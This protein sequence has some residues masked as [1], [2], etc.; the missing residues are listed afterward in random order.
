[1]A[2]DDL[3]PAFFLTEGDHYLGTALARGPWD[4]GAAH[5]GPVAALIGREVE[6][7]DPDPDLA[8][9]RLTIELLRPVPLAR[10]RLEVTTLRP[11]RRVRIIGVSVVHDGTE[12]ARAVA[13]RV[14]RA[15]EDAPRSRPM[16]PSPFV[17]PE[18]AAPASGLVPGRVGITSGVELRTAAGSALEPGPATYWFRVHR[19]LVDYEPISPLTRALIAADFG[20]GISSVVS[21]DSHVFINPDLTVHLHRLPVGEW[22]A[23]DAVTWLE[24]GGAAVADATLCDLDG[25][26]GRAVQSLY[27]ASR[28]S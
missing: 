9:V 8:T 24:P 26:I 3:P 27:V 21:I 7:H 11:G 14:R 18:S 22:I 1:M 12:V 20:N 25:P 6:R 23:N 10:L 13:L 15:A 17:P 4:P 2:T 28:P 19:P 5:G 16:A